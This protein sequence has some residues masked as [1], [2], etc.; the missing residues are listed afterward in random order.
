MGG[1]V[2]REAFPGGE[3][4]YFHVPAPR[5]ENKLRAPGISYA[6]FEMD[7]LFTQLAFWLEDA[8]FDARLMD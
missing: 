7:D 1:S 6:R 4:Y 3:R 5:E 8:D 2:L